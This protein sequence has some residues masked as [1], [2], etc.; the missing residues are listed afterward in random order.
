MSEA[1]IAT[2]STNARTFEKKVFQHQISSI[3]PFESN[4][5]ARV[6]VNLAVCSKFIAGKRYLWHTRMISD[7]VLERILHAAKDL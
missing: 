6:Y 3:D 1:M 2:S 5:T 7:G 4:Q